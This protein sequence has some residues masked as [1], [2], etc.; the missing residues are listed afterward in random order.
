MSEREVQYLVTVK[1][2]ESWTDEK[3][4]DLFLMSAAFD[5]YEN[6]H[7]A[8]WGIRYVGSERVTAPLPAA[9]LSAEDREALARDLCET[10]GSD[11]GGSCRHSSI[12]ITYWL[13]MAD[14]LLARGW[15]IARRGGAAEERG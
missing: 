11:R 13:G 3:L 14:R 4:D 8:V 2:T 1:V 6:S 7:E 15:V 10:H 5:V 12:T 9:V